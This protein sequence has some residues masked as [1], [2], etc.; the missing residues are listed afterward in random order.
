MYMVGEDVTLETLHSPDDRERSYTAIYRH[1]CGD[2]E[3]AEIEPPE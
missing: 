3:P 2:R 1:G